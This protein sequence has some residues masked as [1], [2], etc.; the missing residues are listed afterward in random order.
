MEQWVAPLRSWHFFPS[1][2]NNDQKQFPSTAGHLEGSR[3]SPNIN[4][5]GLPIQKLWSLSFLCFN[6]IKF[7]HSRFRKYLY[8]FYSLCLCRHLNFRLYYYLSSISLLLLFSDNWLDTSSP[9]SPSF[10]FMHTCVHALTFTH[11]PEWLMFQKKKILLSWVPCS[12]SEN[13]FVQLSSSATHP[14]TWFTGHHTL[15]T[16]QELLRSPLWFG[17]GYSHCLKCNFNSTYLYQS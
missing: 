7:S 17:S 9:L 1:H 3:R 2:T 10:S 6:A 11:R 12:A 8:D 5:N 4:N 15:C 13:L 14:P 16:P